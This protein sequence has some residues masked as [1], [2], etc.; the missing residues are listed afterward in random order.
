MQK[1]LI[2]EDDTAIAAIERDYLLVEQFEVV[3]SQD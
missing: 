2:I 1:I 3:I